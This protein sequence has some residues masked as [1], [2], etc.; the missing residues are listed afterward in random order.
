MFAKTL[1]SCKIYPKM[2]V[3]YTDES[4]EISI[5]DLMGQIR[6]KKT[7][8]PLLRPQCVILPILGLQIDEVEKYY[9]TFF[10]SNI[11]MITCF[12]QDLIFFLEIR[13]D[14]ICERQA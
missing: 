12:F 9:F 4:S 14:V 8:V 7:S 13:P 10:I 11:S 3:H 5:T 1:N 6:K 2:F